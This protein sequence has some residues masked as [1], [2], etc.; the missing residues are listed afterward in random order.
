MRK[1]LKNSTEKQ[2]IKGLKV[3]ETHV[4]IEISYFGIKNHKS[5]R[6]KVSNQLLIF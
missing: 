6:A 4:E 3:Q 1:E 5:D 2:V